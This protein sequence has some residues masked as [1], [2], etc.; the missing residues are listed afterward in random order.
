MLYPGLRVSR[1]VGSDIAHAVPLTLVAGFGHWM[2]GDVNF[3]LLVNLLVGS[4]PAVIVGSLL[5]SRA[6]DR[7]LRPA[8]AV[9]LLISG[10][11]L[12]GWWGS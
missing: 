12:L 1:I 7:V 2:N 4:I 9:V 8:L 10:T 11:K 5:S 6:P 3:G